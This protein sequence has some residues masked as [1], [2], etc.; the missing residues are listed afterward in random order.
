M[1]NSFEPV[2]SLLPPPPPP[3]NNPK[4]AQKWAMLGP[5]RKGVQKG[6]KMHVSR[7]D[8]TLACY[9]HLEPMVALSGAQKF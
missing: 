5:K 2:L 3:G 4:K 6:P 7:T 1:L 9:F 8:P